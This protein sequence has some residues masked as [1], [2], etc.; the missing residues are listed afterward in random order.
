M[1]G[2]SSKLLQI[3]GKWYQEREQ[4]KTTPEAKNI[5]KTILHPFIHNN[6][7]LHVICHRSNRS[8][9]CHP[10]TER[11]LL[12][13]MA[14]HG[15]SEANQQPGGFLCRAP[16][17]LPARAFGPRR[18]PRRAPRRRALLP[19]D[20]WLHASVTPRVAEAQQIFETGLQ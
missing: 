11:K 14:G 2:S 8:F 17:T 18:A 5:P 4:K 16:A 10:G 19:S 7:E 15:P 9:I 13:L 1:T 20:Q 6:T 12:C 3:Q